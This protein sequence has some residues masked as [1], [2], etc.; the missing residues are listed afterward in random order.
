ME[1]Y[2]YYVEYFIQSPPIIQL[3]WLLS[4]VFFLIITLLTAYL[5]YLR[6]RLRSKERIQGIYQKKYESEL[7]TYLYS[8]N[9]EEDIS[10]EQQKV[11]NYFKKYSNSGLNRKIIISTLLKLRNEI[12][13]EMADSI[14][15]LYYQTGLVSYA[16]DKLK[17]KKWDVIAKSIRELTQFQIKEAHDAIIQHI[18]HPKREVRKEVQMY[19]VNLFY[20]KGLDFLNVLESHLTE[21]DQ[22]Q[23]LEIL[24]RFDDQQIPN[25]N[26]WLKSSNDSVV[27]F[28]L[29]LAKIY[30]QFET[31]EEL[32]LL[33]HHQNNSIRIDAINVLAHLNVFEAIPIIK[34]DFTDRSI[35]EQVAFFNM[36]EN[37]YESSDVPFILDYLNND[38]FEIKVSAMKI[39]KVLNKE[40]FNTFK[41]MTT[42]PKLAET[43]K[44]IETN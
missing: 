37:M 23:L 26:T 9:D 28:T 33:L 21:W 16:T 43:V 2:Q 32:L 10:I 30:N 38:N 8:G 36:M 4:G 44:F 27:I 35:E 13:G 20:F 22:I 15:N 1:V 19:L 6:S 5:K 40:K 31:K 29:K 41:M 7:I 17:S 34:K 25:I 39:L 18:N 24:Q 3:A 14:Q 11:I 42:D 12:S